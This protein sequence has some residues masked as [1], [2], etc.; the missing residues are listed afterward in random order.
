[1]KPRIGFVMEQTLGH[2]AYAIGLREALSDR[3]DFE[4]RWIHV[5]YAPETERL[6]P[7]VGR[8][9]TLRGGLRAARAVFA[10][11]RRERLDA[12]FVHTQTIALFLGPFM[13]RI[14]TLL[15][16][17]ATPKNYDTVAGSYGDR[18]HAAPIESA[19]LL[20]HRGIVRRARRYTT[21][22]SWAKSSLVDDYGASADRVTVVHPGTVLTRFP[23]PNERSA[24][25]EGPLRVLFVGGDFVRKGGDVLLEAA[26]RMRHRAELHLVTGAD[27]PAADGVH[28][29]RGLKP[30]SPELLRLY[31]DADV[32]ALP[33]R[34]DCLAVVLGE[35]MAACLPIVTTA[36]GA[37]REAVEDDES[38][39]I[40]PTDDADAV[41]SR[42]DRLASNP[43]LA[44]RLGLRGRAIGE[45][46]FDMKK[47]A[48][49]IADLLLETRS[50]R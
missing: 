48:N 21:W 37:H 45:E 20:A 4:A 23:N 8:N 50:P 30:L 26:R 38:G 46:R 44:R 2:V 49:R 31:A 42:L 9:W 36:V 25:R 13:R 43:E 16:T 40:V 27:V 6:L 3:T 29:Y 22:S 33:T 10:E 19:K 7:V 17:D 47:N 15:S 32:F 12:L 39:Y 1:V 28:V 18:V 34:G 35:A 11:L 14:P 24:R 5:P 41:A